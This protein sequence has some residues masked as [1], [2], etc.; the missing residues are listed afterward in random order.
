[1]LSVT[2]VLRETMDRVGVKN[3]GI[4]AADGEWDIA[5]EMLVDPYLSDAVQIV[6]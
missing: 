1:M 2:K 4:I 3:I 5:N 6:G